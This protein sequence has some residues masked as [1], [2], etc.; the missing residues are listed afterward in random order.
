MQTCVLG[1]GP[2][3]MEPLRGVLPGVACTLQT[4][5]FSPVKEQNTTLTPAS[6]GRCQDQVHSREGSVKKKSCLLD[7]LNLL[8]PE[9]ANRVFFFVFNLNSP[10]FTEKYM[11]SQDMSRG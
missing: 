4:S 2:I 8:Q 10:G 7:S 1:L 5:V 11:L 3:S 6:S 9:S